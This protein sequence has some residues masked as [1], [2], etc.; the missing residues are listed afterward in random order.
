MFSMQ[1]QS[2]RKRYIQL[3]IDETLNAFSHNGLLVDWF[4]GRLGDF[5]H[6]GPVRARLGV[7]GGLLAIG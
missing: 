1:G 6:D 2:V 5:Q 7:A 4:H 3:C